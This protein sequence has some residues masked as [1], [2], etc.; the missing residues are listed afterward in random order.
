M[1]KTK[2]SVDFHK[3]TTFI[4]TMRALDRNKTKFACMKR[5][6]FFIAASFKGYSGTPGNMFPVEISWSSKIGSFWEKH[7]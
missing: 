7:V 2:I 3:I 6:N 1:Q 5:N 4:G